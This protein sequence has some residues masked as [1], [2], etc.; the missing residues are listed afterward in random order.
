METERRCLLYHQITRL[1]L[2]KQGHILNFSSEH[3][4]DQPP[5]LVPEATL[6]EA[7]QLPVFIKNGERNELVIEDNSRFMQQNQKEQIK[8]HF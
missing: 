5:D 2:Y 6:N 1:Q 7:R 4:I 3:I 8:E